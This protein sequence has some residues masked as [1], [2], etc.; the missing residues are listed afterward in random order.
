MLN[1]GLTGA[2]SS[3]FS[4]TASTISST[5]SSVFSFTSTSSLVSSFSSFTAALTF[6]F[7]TAFFSTFS[8]D[9]VSFDS[10]SSANVSV[11]FARVDFLLGLTLRSSSPNSPLSIRS[12]TFLI[13]LLAS[14]LF[15]ACAHVQSSPSASSFPQYSHT[16]I[17][18]T[19]CYP[20]PLYRMPRIKCL[21]ACF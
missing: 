10:I 4:S 20:I 19:S 3:A 17:S 8:S 7:F 21:I 14:R 11:F 1:T 9:A 15:C 2:F 18:I 13:S 6:V 5:F 16:P 12:K